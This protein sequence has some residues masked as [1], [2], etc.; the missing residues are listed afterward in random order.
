M[1]NFL[2]H[3]VF[4]Q[5]PEQYCTITSKQP[6]IFSVKKSIFK[7]VSALKG[8]RTYYLKK[9]ISSG[10]Y[11][12]KV[13]TLGRFSSYFADDLLLCISNWYI[14]LF[15]HTEIPYTLAK[16]FHVPI[17]IEYLQIEVAWTNTLRRPMSMFC[18]LQCRGR[19]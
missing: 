1:N 18:R 3:P 14:F 10:T 15:R 8:F 19:E 7:R 11:I 5:I 17:A 2:F 6:F 16:N 9:K 13:K 12:I 4:P